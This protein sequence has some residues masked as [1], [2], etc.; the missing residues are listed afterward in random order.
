MR[1]DDKE[2]RRESGK[3]RMTALPVTELRISSSPQMQRMKGE[4]VID[5]DRDGWHEKEENTV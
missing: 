4:R 2:E 1:G 3:E 5:G